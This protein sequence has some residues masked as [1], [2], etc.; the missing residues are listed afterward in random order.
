VIVSQASDR[1]PTDRL[2]ERLAADARPVRRLRP[3]MTRAALWLVAVAGVAGIAILSFAN[4]PVLGD[5]MRDASL[6]LEMTGALLAGIAAV[7]AAFHLSLPD[8][9]N[10]W[11]LLP[12]PGLALWLGGSGYGCYS[13][14]IRFGTERWELGDSAACLRFILIA[15]I[16]LGATLLIALRRACPLAPVRV[17]AVGGLGVAALS[18][19]LLQ[20]FHP[21]DVTVL[22]LAVHVLAVGIVVAVSSWSGRII[23]QYGVKVPA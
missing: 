1:L 8:R 15:S 12:A 13:D 20:F 5:R 19:F 4:L 6:T 18:A 23:P 14:W 10:A 2:I 21:F 11:A 16:P 9:P 7:I 17:A 22:D 3:P